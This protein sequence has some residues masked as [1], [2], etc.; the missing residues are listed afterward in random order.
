MGW[1]ARPV[2]KHLGS[3]CR[4]RHNQHQE[5]LLRKLKCSN[6]ASRPRCYPLGDVAY[7]QCANTGA[8]CVGIQTNQLL[9]EKTVNYCEELAKL[10]VIELEAELRSLRSTA[11]ALPEVKGNP[12]TSRAY[13]S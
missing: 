8:L 4:L 2:R 7:S 1:G 5:L 10:S 3:L 11:D 12:Y 13:R 6:R 9:K